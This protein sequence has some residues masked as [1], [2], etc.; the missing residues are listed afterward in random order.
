MSGT[1]MYLVLLKASGGRNGIFK[2]TYRRVRSTSC[3]LRSREVGW[4]NRRWAR[5]TRAP[6]IRLVLSRLIGPTLGSSSSFFPWAYVE[7][8]APPKRSVRYCQHSRSSSDN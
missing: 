2:D 3:G 8:E 5:S 1:A 7:E 4:R 6:D